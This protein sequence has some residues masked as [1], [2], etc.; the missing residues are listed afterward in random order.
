MVAMSPSPMGITSLRGH[1]KQ[2]MYR[3]HS[4]I[5]ECPT[6]DRSKAQSATLPCSAGARSLTALLVLLG[7]VLT[8]TESF[9]VIGIKVRT[10]VVF[11]LGL[12]LRV[13]VEHVLAL[14]HL[15]QELIHGLEEDAQ[16]DR[17]HDGI[18]FLQTPL[19]RRI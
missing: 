10:F 19:D 18:R 1:L 7:S 5:F 2:H 17:Q 11:W 9:L 3:Y 15:L 12:R 14:F 13:H 8:V 6:S 4:L 16:S